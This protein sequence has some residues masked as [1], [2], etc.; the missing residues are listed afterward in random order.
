MQSTG[1][2]ST[3]ALSLTSMHGS[4]ITYVIGFLPCTEQVR[5]P[6]GSYGLPTHPSKWES[7]LK[8]EPG[9]WLAFSSGSDLASS[10]GASGLRGGR[11]GRSGPAATGAALY[12]TVPMPSKIRSRVEVVHL[13]PRE[14]I[15]AG[16]RCLMAEALR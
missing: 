11:P 7:G 14:G 15:R 16:V 10:R 4:T 2:T 1:Q 8:G 12:G 5:R 6:L 13:A 9:I 3:Q